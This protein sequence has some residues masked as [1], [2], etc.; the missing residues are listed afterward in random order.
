MKKFCLIL[1]LIIESLNAQKITIPEFDPVLKENANCIVLKENLTT[2]I[3]AV[4]KVNYKY[5]ARY[6]VFNE[7]GFKGIDLINSYNKSNKI[8]SISATAYK[9][10][11]TRLNSF[12]KSQFKDQIQIDG[13]SVFREDRLLYLDY[14]PTVYPFVLDYEYEIESQNTAFLNDWIVVNEF[15]RSVVQADYY[16]VNNAG[17]KLQIVENKFDKFSVEK[18]NSNNVYTYSVKNFPALKEEIYADLKDE[19]PTISINLIKAGLEGITLNCENWQSFGQDYYNLFLKNNSQ[20]SETLKQKINTIV[21]PSDSKI[22]KIKKVYKYVQD[23]TRYV[24]IQV[25]IGGWKPMEIADVE[26]FGYGDCKALSN[27]TRALLNAV[28]VESYCTLIYGGTKKDINEK[29]VSMQGNHMILAVPNEDDYYFLECT[30]QV[31]PFAFLG[32]FT[33][34]RKALIVKPTGGEVVNTSGYNKENN[35]Q[36][37]LVKVEVLSDQSINGSFKRISKSTLYDQLNGN[38]LESV[39]DLKKEYIE[40]FS[41]INN[42]EISNL[43]LTNDKEKIVFEDGFDFKIEKYTT[44][45]A[46]GII[47]PVNVFNKNTSNLIR[48][49]NRKFGFSIS[50]GI[51][52]LDEI[53]FTIP[54]DFDLKTLPEKIVLTSKFGNY[55]VEIKKVNSKILYQRKFELNEGTYSNTDYEEFRKFNENINRNDNLK[56]VLEKK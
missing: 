37:S 55:T 3:N 23:N 51:T 1:L 10:D 52:T 48:Y 17:I 36:Y 38:E 30:S 49:R 24:S 6:L 41:H 12:S 18:T 53:E 35:S 7:V 9:I 43:K 54:N 29:E 4:D 45:D 34:N 26:Q 19:V 20:V 27:F 25:G 22:D 13:F 11:G 32:K 28:G 42:L 16:I 46:L 31:S 15:N 14:T 47:L 50:Y 8:K 40:E 33:S 44:N 56:I 2:E 5:K 39:E 21:K